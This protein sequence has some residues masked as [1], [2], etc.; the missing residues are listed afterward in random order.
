MIK[1]KYT[2]KKLVL[3]A[4]RNM[5]KIHLYKK[6]IEHKTALSVHSFRYE[7]KMNDKYT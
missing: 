1:V 5:I 3:I 6:Y 4:S 2:H 7:G